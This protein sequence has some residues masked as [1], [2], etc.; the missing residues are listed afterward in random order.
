MRQKRMAALLMAVCVFAA[1]GCGKKE[2]SNKN[3]VISQYKG[4]EA[5]KVTAEKAQDE[6]VTSYIDSVLAEN[7][8]EVTDRALKEGD[9]AEFEY[10]GTLDG[11][12]FDEGTLTLGNGE[13]YVDGF[14]EG[15]YGHKLNETFEFPVT[16]PEGYGGEAKPELSGADVIFEVKITS[17]KEGTIPELTDELVKTVS[18]K[19]KTVDEYKKE[20]KEIIQK[21]NDETAQTGLADNAWKAVLENV[22]VN[23]YP[24]DRLKEVVKQLDEQMKKMLEYYGTNYEDYLAQS[25]MTEE[26]FSKNIEE[27]AKEYLKQV[28]AAELI[29]EKEG[30][31]LS[32]KDYKKIMKEYA[33]EYGYAN[34]DDMI[35]QVGET[36]I[37][38]MILQDKVKEFVAKECKQVEPKE[39]DTASEET[40]G[41]ENATSE[42][43]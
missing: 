26:E 41:E 18:K 6:D 24:K 14:V 5:E 32:D 12:V 2:I 10:K 13:T 17:I 7:R 21:S 34:V 31:K 16:F 19:S 3:V 9:V 25:G 4:V 23:E 36:Q 22:K 11:K 1:A 39:E 37:K 27:S 38:E 35:A 40:T 29:A 42:E 30:I 43:E 20:V 15:I 28:L 33:E 8:K